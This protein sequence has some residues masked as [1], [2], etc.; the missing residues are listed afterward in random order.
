MKM[1]GHCLTRPHLLPLQVAV[2]VLVQCRELPL[3]DL[4]PLVTKDGAIG[5]PPR[6]EQLAVLRADKIKQGG[7]EG[8]SEIGGQCTMY[9]VSF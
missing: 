8:R 7:A 1:K 2:P 9:L 6:T 4:L 5:P 3:S